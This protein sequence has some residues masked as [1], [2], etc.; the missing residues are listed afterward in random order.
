LDLFSNLQPLPRTTALDNVA[1]PMIYAGFQNRNEN[2]S[3]R[4]TRTSES[5]IEWITNPTNFLEDNASVWL[6]ACFGKQTSIILADEPWKFRQQNLLRNHETFGDIHERNTVILV[7]H[8]E[9]MPLTAS[10]F[11]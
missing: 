7:T 10:S 3:Y 2:K 9:E 5:L 8:E 11:A 1:L 6:C 4:S